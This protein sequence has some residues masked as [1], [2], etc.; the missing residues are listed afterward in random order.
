MG[1]QEAGVDLIEVVGYEASIA[2][3][4]PGDEIGSWVVLPKAVAALKVPVIASGA[5]ANG[6]Q[7]AAA[8]AMG[9]Q[10]ITMATRFLCTQ[11]API[12]HAI[13]EHMASSKVDERCSLVDTSASPLSAMAAVLQITIR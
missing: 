13:K 11:E 12:K 1:A 3:G 5:S 6:K 10:G 2:G 7:L 4:Q 8:L 9:A